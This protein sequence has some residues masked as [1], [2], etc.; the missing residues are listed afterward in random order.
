MLDPMHP[1]GTGAASLPTH[2]Q[3]R[4]FLAAVETGGISAAARRLGLTQP[5]A[6][7][8]VRELE[9]CLGVR[10]LERVAGRVVPTAAGEAVLAPARRVA[11]ALEDVIAASVAHRSAET[12]RLRFGTG[13]TACIYRLPPVLAA[14]RAGMPGLEVRIETGNSAAVCERVEQGVLDVGL[15][16]LPAPGARRLTI[17]PLQ[18]DPLHALIPEALAPAEGGVTPAVLGAMP[19]ILYEPAGTTR[20]LIDAWFRAGGVEPQP[21]MQL[22]SIETIKVL[23]AGGLGASVMPGMALPGPVPQACIRPLDPPLARSLALVV[24]PEKRR[25]RGL[26]LLEA[27]LAG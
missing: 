9:R 20:T 11:A 22:D 26:R 27:A 15:V 21:R 19:L 2:R 10:L 25:D 1:R 18:D 14:L 24:R 17:L 8:Q 3:L 6:S 7:Q 4:T 13:A 12:G 5:A 16:T 23:V